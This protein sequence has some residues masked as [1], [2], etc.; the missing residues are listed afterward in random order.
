MT[1]AGTIGWLAE[2]A[3]SHGVGSYPLVDEPP[4]SLP[5]SA[6]LRDDPVTD[7]RGGE[8]EAAEQDGGGRRY[9]VDSGSKTTLSL[10]Y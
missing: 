6:H 1:G 8:D 4:P 3:D 5:L 2:L 9:R 7:G 10:K